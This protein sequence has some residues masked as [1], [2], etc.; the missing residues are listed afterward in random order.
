MNICI[1]KSESGKDNLVVIINGKRQP[2]YSRYNPERD[3]NRFYKEHFTEGDDFYIFIGLGLGYHIEPFLKHPQVKKII[4]LEPVEEIYS[5]VKSLAGIKQ[6]HE[7][8]KVEL[9][10]GKNVLQFIPGIKGC[11]DYLFYNRIR[12]LSYKPLE[13]IFS[14]LYAD[15]E[16]DIRKGLDDLVKDGVTIGKFART[17]LRNFFIN[18]KKVDKLT[19][20]FSLFNLFKGAAVITGAG[21][22]LD[23]TIDDIK[24]RRQDFFLI[25]TDASVKPLVRNGILP[26]L[27]VTI[28]PQSF[29][30]Y[31]FDGLENSCI[32]D[33]PAVLSFLSYPTVFD[34]FKNRYIFFSRHP[35]TCLFDMAR[36]YENNAIL[37]YQAVSS[38][39]LKIALH[40]GFKDIYL[41]GFDFSYPEMR[42][43][44][45][46]TF[47]Y[48]YTLMR[49]VRFCPFQTLEGRTLLRSSKKIT[50]P[51]ELPLYTSLNLLDYLQELESVIQ[52][53][54]GFNGVRIKTWKTLGVPIKG[55]D[56]VK[57]PSF[58]KISGMVKK[59][60]AGMQV[61]TGAMPDEG[62]F[63]AIAVT[64]AIRNRI[65]KSI[66]QKEKAFEKS[67]EYLDKKD[68]RIWKIT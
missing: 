19:P 50:G 45:K 2:V 38:M 52:E 68:L 35:T 6:I 58:V 30:H 11:Y 48:D 27:I 36:L 22:S 13:R 60:M 8:G 47:F 5:E 18:I 51:G 15:I 31:H 66:S 7:S 40:M 59:E 39:A 61:S 57:A 65:F 17:W 67:I 32:D 34:I 33:V 64:L 25:A 14:S 10:S 62:K 56:Y 26:D 3:G 54:A 49:C 44:A 55:A 46:D 63:N 20:V 4:I 9:F 1:E 42:M 12:V 23:R 21:P 29:V 37:N 53:A 41:T 43:Y 24:N 16:R 28:D